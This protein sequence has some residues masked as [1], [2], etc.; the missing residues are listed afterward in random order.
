MKETC[1]YLQTL[2]HKE[3][4][5]SQVMQV[6]VESW[7][8][9]ELLLALPLKPNINHM[10]SAFGGSL[11]CGAVLAGWG[12]M[13]L[14]LRE[15]GVTDGHIVI[16]E[17]QIMYPY[18]VLGDAQVICH[19]PDETELKKFEKTFRRYKKGRLA[20]TSVVLYEGKEAV[21]F[22]GQYVVY[23]DTN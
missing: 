8:C 6:T 19:A 21:K 4:P 9:R 13:H 15:L 3:I 20:L 11:Y 12:W 22:T 14:Y 17:G 23:T 18:P 16:Q 7:E 1:H 2:L 10:S 5:I